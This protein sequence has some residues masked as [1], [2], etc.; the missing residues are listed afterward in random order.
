MASGPEAPLSVSVDGDPPSH[1]VLD[2][3]RPTWLAI[4]ARGPDGAEVTLS[5]TGT[6]VLD[7]VVVRAR[8]EIARALVAGLAVGLIAFAL[9]RSRPRDEAA[10]LALFTMGATVFGCVPGW[11][12]LAWPGGATVARTLPPI[13]IAIFGLA[14]AWARTRQRA[15]IVRLALLIAAGLFGAWVR[16][17]FLPAAGSWDVDF[18]RTAILNGSAHG[19]AATYGGRDDVPPATSS[20]S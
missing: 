1:V 16:A 17:Y 10:G 2:P 3:A 18:W 8:P 4:P 13:G 12:A 7:G 5:P 19:C 20:R 15:A 14:F 9:L 6:A 11:I